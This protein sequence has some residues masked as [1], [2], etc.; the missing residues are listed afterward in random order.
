MPTASAREFTQSNVLA[1]L[2]RST[3]FTFVTNGRGQ[4]DDTLQSKTW[5]DLAVGLCKLAVGASKRDF[6]TIRYA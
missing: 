3:R 2:V 1:N 6:D 4:P 5:D